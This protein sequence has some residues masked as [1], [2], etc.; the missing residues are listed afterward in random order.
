M[1]VTIILLN[2]VFITISLIQFGI[3]VQDALTSTATDTEMAII[4]LNS[5]QFPLRISIC[6]SPGFD[7][8]ELEKAGYTSYTN[9]QLGAGIHNKS[10][11]GKVQI[12]INFT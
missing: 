5:H 12:H 11:L 7:Q 3:I 2:V 4:P 10:L 1:N 6:V 8:S 9:Y